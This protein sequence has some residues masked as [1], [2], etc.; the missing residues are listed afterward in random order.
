MISIPSLVGAPAGVSL[1]VAPNL[2]RASAAAGGGGSVSPTPT[3]TPAP[4][5]P[6]VS[7]ING[8]GSSSIVGT[9]ST[10]TANRFL[11]KVAAALNASTI[12]NNGIGGTVIQASNDVSGA[13]MA[14]NGRG[15]FVAN[16]LGA[17]A[18]DLTIFMWPN[19]L[20]YTGN[21]SEFNL[22]G[23]VRDMRESINGMIVAGIPAS[24]IL[25]CSPTWYD[26]SHYGIGGTGFTGSTD[27]INLTYQQATLDLAKEYGT[28]YADIYTAIRDNGGLSLFV[29][30]DVH[31]NDAGHQVAA[32]AALAA[33]RPNT[34]A[35]ITT[36]TGTSTVPGQ[37][38]IAGSAVSGAASYE[39][40]IDVAAGYTYAGGSANP[41][42]LSGSFTGLTQGNGY[43]YRARAVFGD[44]TKSA[45]TFG[46]SAVTIASSSGTT[47]FFNDT[48]T[49]TTGDL[50]S[51]HTSDSGHTWAVQSGTTSDV[52]P[53][54]DANRLRGAG[55]TGAWRAQLIAPTADYDVDATLDWLTTLSSDNVAICGRMQPGANTFYWARFSQAAGGFELYKT[56]AGASA[57]KLGATFT[58][59]FTSGSRDIRLRMQGSAISFYVTDMTTPKIS[60]TDADIAGAG[61]PGFRSVGSQTTGTGR[62]IDRLK[63]TAL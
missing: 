28:F 5:L 24:G 37:L 63:A 41:A 18:S 15:R 56:V 55:T 38:D 57:V 46:A 10:T 48:F 58:D 21:P 20:R 27:A 62:E 12:R 39:V 33:T 8:F 53:R 11:N 3:P 23:Y 50:I 25:L 59:A 32:T 43:K 13:P 29:S 19:D 42:T 7:S 9:G 34:T 31:W 4:T 60:V 49:G 26:L 40:Q 17:N 1:A 22:A 52:T 35:K 36:L 47:P 14:N 30:G 2:A 54:I 16:L 45:W 6:N 61:S 44:G 51:N